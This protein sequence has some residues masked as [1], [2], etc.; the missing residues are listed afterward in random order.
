M[1]GMAM[2]LA[3]RGK[4]A[5]ASTFACFFTRA[6]D[7]IRVAAISRLNVKL[8][9]THVGVSIGEDGPTQMGLED[10]AMICAEPDFTALYPADAT[11]A[12]KAAGLIAESEGPGYVR[13]GRMNSPILYGPDEQFTIG[14]CK[15]LRHSDQDRA[16]VVAAGVTVFEALSAYDELQKQGILVRVID[17]FSVQPIDRDELVASARTVGGVVITVEDHYAHGGLGDAVLAALAEERITLRKLAVRDIA[18]SGKP[19]ELLEKFGISA[20]HIASAVRDS[21]RT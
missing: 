16:L 2:G 15:V 18:R 19:Q 3:A 9:G 10:L 6:Y 20:S 11:S 7:F 17:L 21:V 4:I 1:L 13:L 5:F 8:A 14:K 12:W